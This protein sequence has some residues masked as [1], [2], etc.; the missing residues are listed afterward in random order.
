[1]CNRLNSLG[2]KPVSSALDWN[3]ENQHVFLLKP[4]GM[5]VTAP[6]RGAVKPGEADRWVEKS[7]L[8]LAHPCDL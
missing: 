4:K 6:E 7:R 1:M 5:T 3:S 2:A 8:C